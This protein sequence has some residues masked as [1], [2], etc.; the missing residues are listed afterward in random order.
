LIFSKKN[1][2]FFQ[3]ADKIAQTSN[4][5]RIQIGC[6]VVVHNEIIAVGANREKTH[7]KQKYYNEIAGFKIKK[8][9]IHAEV[10]AL[11]KIKNINSLKNASIYI[12]RRDKNG[13]LAIS[14]PCN[15]CMSYIKQLGIKHIYYTTNLGYNYEKI[16]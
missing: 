14:R 11:N 5:N 4:F 8:N 15:A 13:N 2:K 6:I 7:P 16:S 10:N 3:V 12:H 1:Y 9:F